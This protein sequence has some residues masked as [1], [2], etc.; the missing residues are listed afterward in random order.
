MLFLIFVISSSAF[1]KE[2]YSVAEIDSLRKELPRKSG[3]KKATIQLELA[4][5]VIEQDKDEALRLAVSGLAIAKKVSDGSLQAVA[6]YILGRISAIKNLKSQEEAYYDTALF[7]SQVSGNNR[8]RG[9]I[10]YRQGLMKHFRGEEIEAL[11][12]FNESLRACRLSGNFK[13]MGSSYSLMG[14]IFRVM[15]LYDRAIEYVI[16]ARLNYEKAG[17]L[18]GKAWSSYILGRIYVDLK[19]FAKADEYFQEALQIYTKLAAIDGNEEGVAISCE[20]IGLL[21]I[22]SGDFD[23]A[24]RCIGKTLEIFTRRNSKFGLANAHKNFGIIEYAKGNYDL[25][26]KNLNNAIDVNKQVGDL[27]ILPTIYEYIGLCYIGKGKLNEGFKNLKQGLEVANKNQQKRI[28]QNIYSKLAD[29]YL[30]INDLKNLVACQKKQIEIQN[31][32]LLEAA[33]VKYEQL[34]G[35]YEIDKKNEQILELERQNEV[36]ALTIK[37]HRISQFLMIF[38][39]VIA[40]LISLSVYWFYNKIRKKNLEL[41]EANA[42]KDKLFAIIAHDLRGP[43]GSLTSFLE[44]LN[45]SFNDYSPEELKKILL[46]LYKSADDVHTLLE[47]LL[48]W[49]RSQLNKIEYRPTELQLSDVIQSSIKGLKQLAEEKQIEINIELSDDIYIKADLNMIQ[50]VVRNLVSNAIKFTKRGGWIIVRA[51]V[52]GKNAVSISI[53]DNGVGIEKSSLA[54]V[55]DISNTLHTSGTENERSTGLGLILVKEFVDRNKGSV[56]IESEKNKGTTV[57]F[58]LPLADEK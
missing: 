3:T 9:E 23:E 1:S 41:K 13:I 43:S 21:H 57:S 32:I 38:G 7:L 34:Q 42:A 11:K 16:N 37:Q 12:C 35:I 28:Q 14:T 44:F 19:L 15:G 46:S 20:Q 26:L 58:T 51:E 33:D 25:A 50:T 39:I 52:S 24:K 29:V 2:R 48:G 56:A 8:I 18:E 17:S 10:L 36:S 4:I 5:H 40:L 31:S 53:A 55:F 47:N 49:A 45:E 27:L 30:K 54:G 22:E 6:Y